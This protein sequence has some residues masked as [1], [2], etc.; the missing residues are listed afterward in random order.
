MPHLNYKWVYT[1]CPGKRQ[2]CLCFK[3]IITTCCYD[4]LATALLFQKVIVT[5]RLRLCSAS[6]PFG[7]LLS[8][9][10]RNPDF[11]GVQC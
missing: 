7:N 2:L 8:L 3:V 11:R 5:N 1:T 4:Y 10:Y 9:N 6:P